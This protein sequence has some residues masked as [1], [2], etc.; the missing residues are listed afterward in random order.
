MH[1]NI[2]LPFYIRFRHDIDNL[3]DD[4]DMILDNMNR[5]TKGREKS[6]YSFERNWKLLVN[7]QHLV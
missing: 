3:E 5:Q 4:I 1:R 6:E 2:W 7:M